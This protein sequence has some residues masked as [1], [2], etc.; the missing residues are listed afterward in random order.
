MPNNRTDY[1]GIVEEIKNRNPIEDVISGYV[2]LKRSGNTLQ[3]SCPFHSDRTPSFTV[4]PQTRSYY[5]FGCQAS[6][7]VITFVMKTENLDYIDAVR[8]LASRSGISM[9]EDFNVGTKKGTSR[10]RILEINLEAAKFFRGALFDKNVG[11]RGRDYIAK[12]KLQS[13]VVKHFGLGYAPDSYSMLRDHLKSK[14]F[15]EKEMQDAF[16]C[17]KSEKTSQYYDV[18]RDRLI[19]PIIDTSGN[20]VAFG[21]RRI[22]DDKSPQKYINSSDTAAFKK[23]K[24]LFAMNFARHHCEEKLILCEG[25]LDVISM[26]AAGVENAVATLGTSVTSEHARMLKRYTKKVVLAYDS[27]PPGQ[28]ATERALR[29]MAEVDLDASV[30]MIS[31][32]KDPDEFISRYGAD[33]FRKLVDSSESEFDFRVKKATANLDLSVPENKIKAMSEICDFISGIPSRIEREIYISQTAKRFQLTEESVKS[34]VVNAINRKKRASAR[35]NR[36]AFVNEKRGY[37]DRTNLDFVKYPRLAK[38]EE[39]VI[40]LLF[41]KPEYFSQKIDG[42]PLT[43]E[44]FRS[45]FCRRLFAFFEENVNEGRFDA[46]YLNSEFNPDEVSRAFR[47]MNDR[48]LLDDN[49]PSVFAQLVREMRGESTIRTDD[50]SLGD[51]DSIIELLNK[52]NKDK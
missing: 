21:G 34:D 5:C 49:S 46:G 2:T 13:A 19:I 45:E 28:A 41:L 40:G 15:T 11:L 51:V 7:D 4:Y 37:G 3:G 18:F 39:S 43:A 32:A 14:G 26:H 10:Q 29:I 38:L 52:K 9:P 35:K 27:D 24:T 6:G 36:E 23:S 8:A 48:L 44:D 31:G 20:I 12:R 17:K 33:E 22:E 50:A 42:K 1:A 25:Y 30:L 16:L 47:L